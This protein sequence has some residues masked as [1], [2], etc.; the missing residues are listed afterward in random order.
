MTIDKTIDALSEQLGIPREKI[1][2][3]SRIIEDLGADS[4]DVVE[5]IMN[6]EEEYGVSISD[7]EAA[8]MSTVGDVFKVLQKKVG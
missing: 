8:K 4:L 5:L 2:A 6:I 7:A 1:T 3:N